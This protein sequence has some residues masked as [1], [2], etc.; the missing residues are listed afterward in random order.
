MD[1]RVVLRSPC[2]YSIGQGSFVG[3][4]NSLSAS[5]LQQLTYAQQTLRFAMKLCG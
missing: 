4:E 2:T 1:V 5:P 3:Q